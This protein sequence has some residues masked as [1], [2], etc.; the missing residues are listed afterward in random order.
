MVEE[1]IYP[2]SAVGVVVNEEEIIGTGC[3]IGPNVV[4]TS[5]HICYDKQTGH[6]FSYISFIPA[7][8]KR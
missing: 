8:I 6:P 4:L 1:I 5:A 2:M 3:L 7:S